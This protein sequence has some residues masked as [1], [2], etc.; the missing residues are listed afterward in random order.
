VKEISPGCLTFVVI[1]EEVP[2]TKAKTLGTGRSLS[3]GLRAFSEW[4]KPNC[5]AYLDS[6]NYLSS[7]EKSYV[8]HFFME[9]LRR[10][11]FLLSFDLHQ[12]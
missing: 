6:V 8:Q 3:S 10:Q 4:C 2:A 9:K 1:R 12:Q 11:N 5:Q 7:P